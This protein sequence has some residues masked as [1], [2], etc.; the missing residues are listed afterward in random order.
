MFITEY[1]TLL[2]RFIILLNC[3]KTLWV[4]TEQKKK[5]PIIMKVKN[6]T[7]KFFQHIFGL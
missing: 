7:N 5:K 4:K 6:G 2:K 3:Q 1:E